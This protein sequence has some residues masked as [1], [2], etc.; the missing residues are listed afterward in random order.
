MTALMRKENRSSWD[1]SCEKAFQT[2]KER[3]TTALVIALP[4][5]SENFRVVH[6]CVEER[7]GLC[8]DAEWDSYRLCLETVEILR[9]E[10]SYS[11]HRVG[12]SR[13]CF[14]DLETLPLR[15]HL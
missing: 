6:G 5:G 15:G 12:C 11:L 10:L 9:G 2:L 7:L 13:I 14:E 4:E 1:E 8:V 3:L